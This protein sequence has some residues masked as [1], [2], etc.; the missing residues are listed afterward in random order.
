FYDNYSITIS[1][2]KENLLKEKETLIGEVETM[3][4]RMKNMSIYME[5]LEKKSSEV[6]QRMTEMQETICI[7][8]NEIS[9]EKIIRDRAETEVQQLQ[10]EIILKKND[11]ETANAS[12]EASANNITRLESLIKDQKIA[13]EKMQKEMSKLV[14]KKMNLQT[15][16][17]NA[18]VEIE[19]LEK[20]LFDKKKQIR[21]IKYELNRTRE[22]SA[23][24]KHEKEL[25]DK[26]LMKAEF[27]RSKLE[28]ELKQALINV[29]NAEHNVQTCRK[30]QLEDK[31]RVEILLREKNTIARSKETAF[32]RI[33][34]LNHELL[35]CGH[36]KK[37][38][39]HELDTLIQTIDDMKKQMEVV[40]KERDRYSLAVQGLEQQLESYINEIKLKQTEILDYKKRLADSETKYCQHQSLFEAVRAERNLCTRNLVETQEEVRDLKSK[41]K[42]TS[43][44]IEQLKE[45]I[46]IKE[47]NL[48]KE[49]FL[50]GRVEKEKEELKIDLR[51]SRMEISNLRQQVE[52]AKKKEKNLRQAIQRAD[53]DIGHR[54][55]D[56]DNVMNER[57]ILGTQ[58]VRRN[59]E[60]GL[61]YGRIKVLNRTLQCGE[62]Q[63][64]QRLED[65]RLLK[66]EVKRLRTEKMLFAKNILNVSDLRQEVFHLNRDLT[67]E[68]LKVTALEEEIQT[69]L[70]IHRWQKLEGM[71]PTT[72][73]LIKKVQT[74]QK[75]ILKMSS[76]MIDKERKLKDTE[77]LYVNLRDVLSKQPNLQITTN[78]NKVK[79]LLRKR[80][81]KIKVSIIGRFG[82]LKSPINPI[83]QKLCRNKVHLIIR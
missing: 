70:N 74:L 7:Q 61:Q 81:E 51:V 49:E 45:D 35:L 6:E 69:P 73:E 40:E 44:Q 32:E 43:Q 4:Q 10:E 52:E 15:D 37:K 18:I 47:G 76:D 55:K 60:L 66:F 30:E 33:K 26:R 53:I 58:L 8:M 46:A 14:L 21:N 78:L 27:E 20:E 28:R 77:K 38:I 72:F 17:D 1:K 71:D 50:L 54:K 39:E 3:Q 63:Y 79:N 29:K 65:I 23:K 42:V 31:Q 67:K 19:K 22:D 80:G 64:N 11:L 48:V 16:L 12:I 34:R 2:K 41:L 5:E 24:Y 13:D 68:K 75:R 25:I 59:D 9:R 56:I 83:N 62:I 57:D 36:S 82:Y